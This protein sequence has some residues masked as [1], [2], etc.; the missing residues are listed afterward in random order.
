MIYIKTSQGIERTWHTGQSKPVLLN[1]CEL[2]A[3]CDELSKI[4]RQFTNIPMCKKS[5]VKWRGEMA[6]V[7][8]DN[9]V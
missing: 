3:D 9:L 1:V 5:V 6:Q 4:E 7:I 8:Y 2:Q